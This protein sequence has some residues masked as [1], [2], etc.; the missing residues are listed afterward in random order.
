MVY[1][2]YLS[3]YARP[4][5]GLGQAM[6]TGVSS[7][8]GGRGQPQRRDPGGAAAGLQGL[9]ALRGPGS[10]SGWGAAISERPGRGHRG[11]PGRGQRDP[12]SGGAGRGFDAEIKAN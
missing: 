2:A 3:D 5:G 9:A 7:A 11:R 6:T 1:L 10:W 4:E 12:R 8:G